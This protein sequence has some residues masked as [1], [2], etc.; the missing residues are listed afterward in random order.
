MNQTTM[1]NQSKIVCVSSSGP[2][3]GDQVDPRFGR[4]QYIV[5]ID[6]DA[7]SSKIV[8]NAN[9]GG[10]SGVGI[11]TAQFAINEGADTVI[12]GRVGPKAEQALLAGGIKIIT[13]AAGTIRGV[14]AQYF[15]KKI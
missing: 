3:L 13:G 10:G 9:Q 11:A 6:L 7:L 4:C 15:N 12:T 2:D 14:I 1:Q 8:V 5:I